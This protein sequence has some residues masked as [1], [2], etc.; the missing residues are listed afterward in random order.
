MFSRR[1]GDFI[2]DAPSKH[3]FKKYDVYDLN[4]GYIT[5]FGDTR[6]QQYRDKI[7]FYRDLDHMDLTRR[8]NY[9]SRHQHDNLDRLSA[10]YFSW[11]YL[12]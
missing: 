2:F 6:Y 4:N 3:K 9:Q 11:K 7:G 5:S 10:G 8:A 1:V 12:W